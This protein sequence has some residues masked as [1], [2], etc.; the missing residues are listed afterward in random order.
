MSRFVAR[1]AYTNTEPFF[2][3]WPL[4]QFPLVS[5]V[6]RQLAAEAASPDDDILAGPL[7]LVETWKLED[8]Y[9]PLSWGIAAKETCQSVLLLSHQPISEINN[10]TIGVTNE[11]S[12]SVAL[13]DIILKGR[14]N[15][16]VRLRRGL[17]HGDEAWLVIGDQALRI[18]AGPRLG[19]WNYVTDLANEWWDWHGLPF[20]FAR[21]V[22][23]KSAQIDE[24]NQLMEAIRTS[25]AA[26]L[27]SIPSI[28]LYQSSLMKIPVQA[29][30]EYLQ[31]FIYELGPQE[32]A[33]VEIFRQLSDKM[34]Q[35]Q[36][37]LV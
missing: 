31:G 33:A 30:A 28:A 26:G 32:E 16:Q 35:P 14:Y 3:H 1:I 2:F 36:M 23:N 7:P 9:E 11:S 37:E 20:V 17:Q 5:G 21:W 29:I 22:L 25:L 15:H 24:K 4:H 34:I 8:R 18:F 27:E 6:P 12:T 19:E 13:C 10:I